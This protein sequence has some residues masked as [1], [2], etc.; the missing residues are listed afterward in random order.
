MSGAHRRVLT[1]EEEYPEVDVESFHCRHCGAP[2]RMRGKTNVPGK[3]VM[4]CD[5]CD[6]DVTVPLPGRH[7]TACETYEPDPTRAICLVCERPLP[8]G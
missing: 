8:T 4:V 6:P 1:L 7:C 2:R 3:R 5:T